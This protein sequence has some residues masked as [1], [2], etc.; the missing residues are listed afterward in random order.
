MK[1]R[2]AI[3]AICLG[4][5]GCLGPRAARFQSAE[6]GDAKAVEMRLIGELTIVASQEEV[7]VV[8]VGLVSGL[9]GTGGGMPPE[10]PW[11]DMLEQDLKKR[12]IG[13]S[14]AIMSSPDCQMVLV[15]ARVPAGTRKNDLIDVEVTVPENSRCTSLKGGYL[16]SC[17][18]FNFEN[19]KNITPGYQGKATNYKGYAVVRAEGALI[20]GVAGKVRVA[21]TRNRNAKP[22]EPSNDEPTQ[23]AAYV[24]SGGKCLMDPPLMLLL[25]S[26]LPSRFAAQVADRINQTFPG[27]KVGRDGLAAAKNKTLVALGIPQQYRHDVA[28]YLRVVRAIPLERTPPLDSP[29]RR[30]LA[31]Q[32]L[33]P[34]KC[35]SAAIRLEALG[36]DSVPVLKSALAAPSPLS[37]FAAAQAL[38]YLRKRDGV[39]ELT[40][41]AKELPALRGL[42]LTALA[43]LDESICHVKLAELMSDREPTLRYGAFFALRTLDDRAQEVACEHCKD[44]YW[45]HQVA[46][47]GQPMVHYLTSR[48]TE[49][50]LFGQNPSLLPDARLMFGEGEE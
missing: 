6:E 33:D 9:A 24:W 39:E 46:E 13:N 21:A 31:D 41:L 20:T 15:S 29:Y 11:R 14:K 12:G 28:H 18:L 34:A 4:L 30:Q 49:I 5:L 47:D 3:A 26:E 35:L 50:V 38:T 7:P 17:D 37:R 16:Y 42:C 44:A 45:V 32:L 2:W 48:R 25:N 8:G 1:P 10:S 40:R 27:M 23:R 22:E 36:D 19:A 43:S